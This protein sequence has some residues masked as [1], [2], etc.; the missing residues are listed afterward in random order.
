MGGAQNS[1]AYALIAGT[2]FRENGLAFPG[3]LVDLKPSRTGK[4]FKKQSMPTT[5]RGEFVFRVPA[6]EMSYQVSLAPSGYR[7]EAKD[8]KIVG[9]ERI[10][11]SFLLERAR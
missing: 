9:D 7:P 2:V 5:P 11:L 6:A 10:D 4:G 8:V 1:T 3:V